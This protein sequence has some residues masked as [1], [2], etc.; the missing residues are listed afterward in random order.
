MAKTS[1]REFIGTTVMAGVALTGSLSSLGA[2]AT[3]PVPIIDSHIHLFDNTRPVFTGYMGS[4][5]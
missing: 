3:D 4:Q 5:E 1:R 2:P